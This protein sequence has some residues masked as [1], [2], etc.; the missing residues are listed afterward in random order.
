[1]F[2][3]VEPFRLRFI[4]LPPGVTHPHLTPTGLPCG[5]MSHSRRISRVILRPLRRCRMTTMNGPGYGS[6]SAKRK[7]KQR[8]DS[9]SSSIEYGSRDPDHGLG[10]VRAGSRG[11]DATI[12]EA[13]D[14]ALSTPL[15]PPTFDPEYGSSFGGPSP[16]AHPP[17]AHHPPSFLPP[18]KLLSQLARSTLPTASLN[19]AS[20]AGDRAPRG[21]SDRMA[22][23]NA[24]AKPG[25]SSTSWLKESAGTMA[26]EAFPELDPTTGLPLGSA[27]SGA[28]GYDRPSLYLQRTITDLL[29]NPPSVS[30]DL[31]SYIPKIS[32]PSIGLP[33]KS[34]LDSGKRSFSSSA[35]TEAWWPNGWWG[36]NKSKVDRHLTE[37]DRA[38][39]VEEEKEKIQRKCELIYPDPTMLTLT[40]RI[41]SRPETPSGFLSWSSRLRLCG[42]SQHASVRWTRL[43]SWAHLLIHFHSLQISHWR[44]IREVLESNGVEVLIGRVPATASIAD[45]AAALEEL[46]EEK[47]PGR[48]VNLIGHSMV[49]TVPSGS[50]RP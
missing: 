40:T 17:R 33:G 36:N 5:Y 15:P 48:E 49:S 41:R 45:R 13:I 44:G 19:Y 47:F 8:A 21:R 43:S 16:I 20:A 39:T 3:D 35:A 46:I 22:S 42:P 27:S 31:S 38:D 18:P 1:M 26:E 23:Q 28:D 9:G 2:H 34:A 25:D 29:A 7:G 12:P 24:W 14:E 11:S 30:P 37:E 32:L 10:H 4:L 50:L 6:P